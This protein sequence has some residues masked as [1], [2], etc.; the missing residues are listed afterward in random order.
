MTQEFYEE[1]CDLLEKATGA[2]DHHAF[3]NYINQATASLI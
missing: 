1:T 3:A 2:I